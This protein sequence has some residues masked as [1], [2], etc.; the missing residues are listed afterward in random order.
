M[1]TKYKSYSFSNIGSKIRSGRKS[2]KLSQERFLEEISDPGGGEYHGSNIE[3]NTLSN[4]E[5]GDE[6]QFLNLALGKL[7]SICFALDV[8]VGYLLGEYEDRHSIVSDI[9][10]YTGLSK[11]AIEVLHY[12]TLSETAGITSEI[13]D[14]NSRT[15]SFINRALDGITLDGDD[16]GGRRA[17]NTIFSDMEDYVRSDSAYMC[18]G[19]KTDHAVKIKYGSNETTIHAVSEFLRGQL[20]ESIL[21]QLD[22]LRPRRQ[23]SKGGRK[24]KT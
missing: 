17:I 22:Q 9:E 11:Q 19:N 23:S 24:R 7:L 16:D 14:Y 1:P 15:V 10:R 13:R 12:A 3:R 2:M 18:N 8:D 21:G 6:K 4:L 20:K 5:K